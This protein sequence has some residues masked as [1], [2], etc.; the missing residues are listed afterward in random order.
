MS[1]SSS[2]RWRDPTD[3]W[4]TK[5][6]RSITYRNK[7]GTPILKA[8]KG[9]CPAHLV[10]ANVAAGGKKQR[11]APQLVTQRSGFAHFYLDDYQ[12]ERFWNFPIRYV[13]YLSTFKGALSP[14]FSVYSDYPEDIQRMNVYRNR[15]LGAYWDMCNI[16]VIPSIS[17]NLPKSFQWCFDAVEPEGIVSISTVGSLRTSELKRMLIMGYTEMVSRLAPITVIIYGRYPSELDD[18]GVRNVRVKAFYEKFEPKGD[19]IIEMGS[20]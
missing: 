11:V 3:Y 18:F 2:H 10:A 17:W 7:H 8:Y 20:L 12:F 9:T 16:P 1:N 6:F 15:A 5:L 19:R 14:D 13:D 4:N